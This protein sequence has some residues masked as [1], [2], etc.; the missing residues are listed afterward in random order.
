MKN[1]CDVI[2]DLL[3]LYCDGACSGESRHLV[4]EHLRECG[5]CRETYELM[6]SALPARAVPSEDGQAAQAAAGGVEKGHAQGR[7]QGV[8]YRAGRYR[9]GVAAVCL[10]HGRT[11][12]RR[13]AFLGMTAPGRE[14]S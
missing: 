12:R 2:Q 11:A 6:R 10:R 4:E 9:G 1:S 8:F 7:P 5:E 3:P 14:S 13:A